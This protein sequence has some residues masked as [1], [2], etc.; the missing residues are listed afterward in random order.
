[1]RQN[2]KDSRRKKRPK[3][4]DWLELQF[5]PNKRIDG[6]WIGIG[7]GHQ[8]QQERLLARVGAALDLIKRWDRPRYDRLNRDLKGVWVR[9]IPYGLGTYNEA[10]AAC[11]LD[12]RFVLAESSPLEIIAATIVHEATHLRLVRCGIGYDEPLRARVEAVCYRR[13]LAFAAKLPNGERVKQLAERSLERSAAPG[14]LS[15]TEHDQRHADGS[16]EILR[17]AGVPD[18][19]LRVAIAIRA[20]RLS[21]EKRLRRP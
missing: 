8:G 18:W 21:I 7:G 19:L 13:E 12:S 14:F 6:L 10:L 16:L 1:M 5:S 4:S 2:R 20:F 17:Q 3:F 9:A 15:D 11:E